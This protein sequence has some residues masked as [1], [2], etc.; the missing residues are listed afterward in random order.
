MKIKFEINEEKILELAKTSSM[1]DLPRSIFYEAKTQA[2]Q[3]AVKEIKDKLVNTP[4]YD[5]PEYL[6]SQVKDEL[7][8]SISGTIQKYVEQNFN[9][10]KIENFVSVYANRILREWVEKKV[11]AELEEIKADL[12]FFSQKQIDEDAQAEL[13]QNQ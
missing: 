2:V 7:M 6:H 4:Y 13:E 10:K 3:I 12:Q 5:T 8:K 9:E 1:E 11:Y